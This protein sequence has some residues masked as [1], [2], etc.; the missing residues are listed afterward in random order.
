MQFIKNNIGKLSVIVLVC[1][2]VGQSWA[3]F[4]L[5]SKVTT[6]AAVI[7]THEQILIQVVNVLRNATV[8]E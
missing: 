8:Q 7:N 1:V 6:Q 5:N 2:L 3:I 4:N